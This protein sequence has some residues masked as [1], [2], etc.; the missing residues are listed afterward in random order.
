MQTFIPW[1]LM[2]HCT[3]NEEHKGSYSAETAKRVSS[4]LPSEGNAV[5]AR[6]MAHSPQEGPQ[7]EALC[8]GIPPGLASYHVC[9]SP[10]KAQVPQVPKPD[11]E[12]VSWAIPHHHPRSWCLLLCRPGQS[13]SCSYSHRPAHLSVPRQGRGAGRSQRRAVIFSV[14]LS[15]LTNQ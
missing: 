4:C 15:G 3:R 14:S 13:F 6:G 11:L 9:Y 2:V 10:M 5:A 1:V 8:L 12:S 7:R